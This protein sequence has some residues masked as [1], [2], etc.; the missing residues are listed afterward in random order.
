MPAA[1]EIDPIIGVSHLVVRCVECFSAH[2]LR[3]PKHG[4]AS[5]DGRDDGSTR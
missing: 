4:E 5:S 3:L 1:A 2:G